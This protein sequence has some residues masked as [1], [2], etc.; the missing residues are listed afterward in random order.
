MEIVLPAFNIDD[1]I[2]SH[3]QASK[4]KLET[5]QRD[6]QEAESSA[7]NGLTQQFQRELDTYLDSNIQ[8]SLNLKIVPPTQIDALSVCATFQFSNTEITLKR[9]DNWEIS[10]NNS[11]LI[12]PPELLQKTLLLELGK[13]KNSPQ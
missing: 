4:L 8:K 10:L 2:N 1:A 3:W 9:S 7:V 6:R 13:L 11:T 5:I 12:C